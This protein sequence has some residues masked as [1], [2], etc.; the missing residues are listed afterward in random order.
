MPWQL[1]QPLDTTLPPACMGIGPL[2][3]AALTAGCPYEPV[4][5]QGWNLG[6]ECTACW[7]WGC[8]GREEPVGWKA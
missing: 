5:A 4:P 6:G 8:P 2:H 3:Q 1:Q 7:N